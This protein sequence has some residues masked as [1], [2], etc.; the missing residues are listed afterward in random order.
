MTKRNFLYGLYTWWNLEDLF[1]AAQG[2]R[3]FSSYIVYVVT[4]Y[5]QGICC[6]NEITLVAHLVDDRFVEVMLEKSHVNVQ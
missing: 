6:L 1:M 4:C 2:Y 3:Q 5:L